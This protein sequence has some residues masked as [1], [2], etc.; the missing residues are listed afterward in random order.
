MPTRRYLLFV[1]GYDEKE[2]FSSLLI[3][4][5]FNVYSSDK[6]IKINEIN[7]YIN[8]SYYS[9]KNDNVIIIQTPNNRIHDLIINFNKD[10]SSIEKLIK[11]NSSSFNG[12]FLIFDVDHNSNEDIEKM[13]NTF[14]DES[15]GLLLLNSPCLEVI[16]DNKEEYLERRFKHL[17]EYKSII[18]QEIC[19]NSSKKYIEII[20][21]N[22]YKYMLFFLNKNEKDFSE[23][24]I[25]EHPRLIKE[26]INKYNIRVNKKDKEKSYVI[27]RYYSTVLYVFISY[28]KGLTKE[29]ENTEIVRDYLKRKN[30]Y[31][32]IFNYFSFVIIY[33]FYYSRAKK[34]FAKIQTGNLPF[35]NIFV[36]IIFQNSLIIL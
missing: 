22:I 3:K 18:H 5:G 14:N 29:I 27:Y 7:N 2:L 19:K 9:K 23:K 6:K 16:S 1:E 15:E 36:I 34:S 31:E 20:K 17:K 24:N 35:C 25:M 32:L 12:I 30:K 11:E 28:I 26:Y 10:D 33:S 13:F 21:E 8:K 4:E